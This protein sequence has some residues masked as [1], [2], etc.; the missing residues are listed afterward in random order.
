M[1]LV[2]NTD[3]YYSWQSNTTLDIIDNHTGQNWLSH[4]THNRA[5]QCHK[6]SQVLV[7]LHNHMDDSWEWTPHTSTTYTNLQDPNS[8]KY[9]RKARHE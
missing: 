7:L 1:S 3:D 9:I 4:L 6:A 5:Q 8:K 2:V